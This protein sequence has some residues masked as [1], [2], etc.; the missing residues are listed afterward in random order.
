[1]PK[2]LRLQL[3]KGYISLSHQKEYFDE[4]CT[5]VRQEYPDFSLE[6]AFVETTK[7]ASPIINLDGTPNIPPHS[8][9]AAVDV[10]IIN[11]QG[12]PLDFGVDLKDWAT[13]DPL[14]C[15]TRCETISLQA[16]KNRQLLFE[17]MTKAGFVNYFT[18]WWHFSYGDKY[19]AFQLNQKHAIYGYCDES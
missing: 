6:E 12:I 9:G 8:T 16:R 4:T 1:M 3:H 2:G 10:E 14:L 11:D 5:L 15:E 7:L 13:A 19:W 17:V 18:E